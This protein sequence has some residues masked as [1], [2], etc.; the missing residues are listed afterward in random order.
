MTYLSESDNI[1]SMQG[2]ELRAI[3]QR[4]GLSL[5]KFAPVLG[6]HWNTLARYERDE[7]QIPEPVAILARLRLELEEKETKGKPKRK[8]KK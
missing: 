6:V 3:R 8:P 4:F 7:I 5:M 1:D 2:E